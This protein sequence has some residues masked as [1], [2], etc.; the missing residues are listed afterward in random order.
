MESKWTEMKKKQFQKDQDV[1]SN[2]KYY[3]VLLLL[4]LRQ[5][6]IPS[7]ASEV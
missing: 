3:Y 2:Q 6:P 1:K 7:I 5:K 4:L